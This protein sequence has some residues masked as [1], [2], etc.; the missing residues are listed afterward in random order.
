MNIIYLISIVLAFAFMLFG[1]IFGGTTPN[2]GNLPGFFDPASILIVVGCTVAVV[3]A[4][5]PA[6]MTKSM[7]KHFKI[8]LD[9]KKFDPMYYIDQLTELAQI[10]RKNGLLALEEKA[11]EQTDPFFK[12][13]IM[14]IVDANDLNVELLGRGKALE[15]WSED[16]LLG[17]IR[18]NPAGQDRQL[19]PFVLI[20]EVKE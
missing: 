2:L 3:M 5:F 18:D 1:I 14:L 15:G 6:S 13:A 11:N 12:Q 19:T 20:R 8:I 7:G 9:T 4:S 16:D 17:L 10:A